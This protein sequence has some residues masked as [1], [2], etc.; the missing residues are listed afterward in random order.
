MH[1]REEA[2]TEGAKQDL[3][4]VSGMT[5]PPTPVGFTDEDPPIDPDGVAWDHR[6]ATW[7]ILSA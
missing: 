6:Q 7:R 3:E 4:R 2:M 5:I 1:S